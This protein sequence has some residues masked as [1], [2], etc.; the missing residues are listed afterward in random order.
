MD[1]LFHALKIIGSIEEGDR[2]STQNHTIYIE[3]KG[4]LQGFARWY[5]GESRDDNI[6]MIQHIIEDAFKAYKDSISKE[7]QYLSSIHD[8]KESHSGAVRYIDYVA[9][10]QS[11]DRLERELLRCQT[12]LHRLSTTYGE[13]KHTTSRI[14]LLMENIQY[15]L[16]QVKGHR[17][18]ML[19][20]YPPVQR[21]AGAQPQSVP[22]P[23]LTSQPLPP[24]P[25][26]PK[27]AS[28]QPTIVPPAIGPVSLQPISKSPPKEKK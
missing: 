26:S 28:S 5:R 14:D 4:I 18:W 16:Q 10:T 17:Q 2:I 21:P 19:E 13:D 23:A 15:N 27:N 9:T 1:D 8:K 22:V 20:K 7:E 6:Q 3:N 24:V 12:G 11:M 25:V